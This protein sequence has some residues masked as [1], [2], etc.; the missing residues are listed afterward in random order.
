MRQF[1]VLSLSLPSTLRLLLTLEAPSLGNEFTL[2]ICVKPS[3]AFVL[4]S[5]SVK[6][7]QRCLLGNC[8]HVSRSSPP[9]LS[10][11]HISSNLNFGHQVYT[12]VS[13]ACSGGLLIN[14]LVSELP[15]LPY[16][17]I[18]TPTLSP[19]SVFFLTQES[20][21]SI[22]TMKNHVVNSENKA[23][24]KKTIELRGKQQQ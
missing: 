11:I 17:L 12:T 8:F 24:W 18:M 5:S 16:G 3:C 19:R 22:S 9:A 4:T 10:Q 23:K 2:R 15:D 13:V 21:L 1:E 14:L 7:S 6:T 20:A